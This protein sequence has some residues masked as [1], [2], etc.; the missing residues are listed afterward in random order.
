MFSLA[1]L[2]FVGATAS[3]AHLVVQSK[4]GKTI[5]L[6]SDAGKCPA[7]LG[8]SA[9]SKISTAL[10]ASKPYGCWYYGSR[11]VEIWSMPGFW[12]TNPEEIDTVSQDALTRSFASSHEVVARRNDLYFYS[13]RCD[14]KDYYLAEDLHYQSG[15][16]L[17]STNYCWGYYPKVA[18]RWGPAPPDEVI[19]YFGKSIG[20]NHLYL[21]SDLEVYSDLTKFGIPEPEAPDDVRAMAEFKQSILRIP[22]SNTSAMLADIWGKDHTHV[23]FFDRK[24]AEC[25]DVGFYDAT[26]TDRTGDSVHGCWFVLNDQVDS[27][28]VVVIWTINGKKSRTMLRI[29]ELSLTLA[30]RRKFGDI[31]TGASALDVI[32]AIEGRF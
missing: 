10:V 21:N 25:T 30:W 9:G 16:G 6:T 1:A 17:S 31:Q 18:R 12:N 13:E 19:F 26:W 5:T 14:H 27:Y 22:V 7:S 11:G 20:A 29:E 8:F 23:Q 32:D 4:S 15:K 24:N 28:R 2:W 3:A